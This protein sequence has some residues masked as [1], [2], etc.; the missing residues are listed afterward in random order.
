MTGLGAGLASGGAGPGLIVGDSTLV[1]PFTEERQATLLPAQPPLLVL[2]RRA[3]RRLAFVA[4]EHG[5]DPASSTF[6]MIRRAFDW[7]RPRAVIVEGFPT[8]WGESPAYMVAATRKPPTA[9]TT[10]ERGEAFQA[11]RLAVEH[12]VP[13]W[14]GEPTDRQLTERLLK[15]HDRL[16]VFY[17]QMFGPLAQDLRSGVF[18]GPADPRFDPAFRKWAVQIARSFDEPKPPVDADSFRNWY[19]RRF[20]SPVT[21]DPD[22]TARGGPGGDGPTQR[23]GAAGNLLRDRY[24]FE[25]IV[26]RLNSHGDVLVVYGGSHLANLWDALGAAAGRPSRL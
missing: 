21:S 25:V 12:G 14:G 8:T 24:L 10:Y 13:F 2:Y 17:G 7:L 19:E 22:W 15:D 16:D 1:A 23:V 6:A 5:I 3:G 9:W 26:D 20:A 4:A 18:D 11:I